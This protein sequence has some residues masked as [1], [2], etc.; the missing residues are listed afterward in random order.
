MKLD[1]QR[2]VL[3][4]TRSG[5]EG[6]QLGQRVDTAGD[7]NLIVT[8]GDASTSRHDILSRTPPVVI[9]SARDQPFRAMATI[10]S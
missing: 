7:G 1:A 5:G 10:P 3:W 9:R 6:R 4:A 2:T 8:R